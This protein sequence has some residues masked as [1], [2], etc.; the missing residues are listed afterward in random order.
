MPNNYLNPRVQKTIQYLKSNNVNLL[1]KIHSPLMRCLSKLLFFNKQFTTHFVTTIGNTIYLPNNFFTFSEEDIISILFHE[2]K[3]IE[4]RK[5][6]G[7]IYDI[8]YLFPQ[9]LSVLSLLSLL[10]I[11]LSN[12]W[13]Y[14]LLFLLCLLPFPAPFRYVFELQAYAVSIAIFKSFNVLSHVNYYF[15]AKYF[16]SAEYYWMLPCKHFVA[17]QL[18]NEVKK[19][20]LTNFKKILNES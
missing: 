8:L 14:C 16:T 3:H 10:A 2:M 4:Q 12:S 1:S 18:E 19:A 6:L 13:L 5:K 15:Y 7:F 9:G 11:W 17:R 20:N